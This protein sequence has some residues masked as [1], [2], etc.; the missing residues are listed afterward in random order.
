MFL[1]FG[2]RYPCIRSRGCEN[3]AI[4][5]DD[6][7][8]GL[9]VFW[10]EPENFTRAQAWPEAGEQAQG[11]EWHGVGVVALAE[12]AHLNRPDGLLG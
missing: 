12:S 8:G 11:K 9:N 7:L 5:A 6:S 10:F 1:P 2:A 4:D 3:F